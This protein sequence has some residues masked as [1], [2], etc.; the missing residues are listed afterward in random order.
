MSFLEGIYWT[1]LGMLGFTLFGIVPRKYQKILLF[2]SSAF[3]LFGISDF[4]EIKT[5]AY[6]EPWPLLALKIFC[7]AGLVF[8]LAWFLKIRLTVPKPNLRNKSYRSYSSGGGKIFT[9]LI[10]KTST[11]RLRSGNIR[12]KFI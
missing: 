2:A 12:R 4:I 9:N 11:R 8:S 6:W 1:V 5:G 7:L 10:K 3:V